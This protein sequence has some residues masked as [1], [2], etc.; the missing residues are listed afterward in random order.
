MVIVTLKGHHLNILVVISHTYLLK[1]TGRWLMSSPSGESKSKTKYDV[2]TI[3]THDG[4]FHCDEVLACYMLKLLPE[5]KD[6][7]YV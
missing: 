5:Y 6:A 3:G 2:K 4:H 7:R 1:S